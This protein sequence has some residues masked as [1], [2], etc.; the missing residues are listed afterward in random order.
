MS[1]RK[2]G[3]APIP[4]ARRD[5]SGGFASRI[6][7]I[8]KA[9][10]P[11]PKGKGLVMIL[12]GLAVLYALYDTFTHGSSASRKVEEEAKGRNTEPPLA[13]RRDPETP[14]ARAGANTGPK[15]AVEDPETI[16]I[17]IPKV[18]IKLPEGLP[19]HVA[20]ELKLNLSTLATAGQA[21]NSSVQAD[22][23]A[24]GVRAA[25]RDTPPAFSEVPEALK[26]EVRS[27]LL[28]AFLPVLEV[29]RYRRELFEAAAWL[30]EGSGEESEEPLLDIYLAA[31]QQG[32]ASDRDAPGAI[33]FLVAMP[34]RLGGPALAALDRIIVDKTRPLHVRLLAARVR[35]AE[36]RSPR[37]LDMAKDP[38]VHP[39]LREALGA[40]GR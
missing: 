39:A 8:S 35:P 12:I 10:P 20:R 5:E 14:K 34:G 21:A 3:D 23:M 11:P 6:E 4:S 26:P 31:Y 7:S 32:L 25:L 19:S 40:N 2:P 18:E 27:Q 13:P 29:K 38:K 37:L 17:T 28:E 9:T 33:M 30:A 22:L 36:E 1:T 15:P 24:E 16:E